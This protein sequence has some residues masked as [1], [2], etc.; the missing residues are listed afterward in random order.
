MEAGRAPRGPHRQAGPERPGGARRGQEGSGEARVGGPRRGQEGSEEARGCQE[1]PAE[2][3]R[4]QE[5]SGEAGERGQEGSGEAGG[6]GGQEGLDVPTGAPAPPFW[7]GPLIHTRSSEPKL[8]VPFP[9]LLSIP[10]PLW[11]A[12][13][14]VPSPHH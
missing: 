14:T 4:G 3:R 2:A 6:G 13:R 5:G 7:L 1:G 9:E 12:E 11:R 8:L 10:G